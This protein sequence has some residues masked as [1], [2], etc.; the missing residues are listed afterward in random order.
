MPN[1]ELPIVRICLSR[2]PAVPV[3]AET[4]VAAV[5]P[6]P[7]DAAVLEAAGVLLLPILMVHRCTGSTR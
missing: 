6:R 3:V 2:P 5:E 7:A 1:I 4:L